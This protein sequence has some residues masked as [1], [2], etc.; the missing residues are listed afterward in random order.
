MIPAGNPLEILSKILAGIP[1]ANPTGDP[2]GIL[3]GR[4]GAITEKKTEAFLKNLRN[5]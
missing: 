5:I 3:V 4:L 2:L 1:Q